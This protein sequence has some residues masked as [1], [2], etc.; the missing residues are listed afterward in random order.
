MAGWRT[1]GTNSR[2]VESLDFT[3]EED[4]CADLSPR[5]ERVVR[6]CSS[7]CQVSRDHFGACPSLS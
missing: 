1:M 6:D 7:G 3:D 5:A 4:T 2:A